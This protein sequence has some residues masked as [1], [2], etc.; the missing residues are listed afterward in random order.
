MNTTQQARLKYAIKGGYLACRKNARD[1]RLR[2]AWFA[3]CEEHEQPYAVILE[4]VRYAE[5][6]IDAIALPPEKRL[7]EQACDEHRAL[8]VRYAARGS[9]VFLGP[10]FIGAA[11]VPITSADHYV[12][13]L[14]ALYRR[15]WGIN[16]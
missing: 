7:S 13:A 5:V 2:N 4:R 16:P 11:K 15:D 10:V 6:W 9:F 12:R 1:M 14:L 8:A 3:W